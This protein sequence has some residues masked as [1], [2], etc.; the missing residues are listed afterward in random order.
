MKMKQICWLLFGLSLAASSV[1]R[2]EEKSEK[3]EKKSESAVE[4]KAEASKVEENA[5]VDHDKLSIALGH[6]FVRNLTKSQSPL[7]IDKIIDGMKAEIKKK[8]APMTQEE[9]QQ[10][11][12]ALQVE[13]FQALSEK[14]L[15]DANAF[16]EKN[17]KEKDVISLDPKL[18]Y[19][20]VK[21]G[22]G[23]EVLNE[24]SKPLVRVEGKLLDGTVFSANK[25]GDP[26]PLHLKETV[27]GISKGMIGMKK[28]EK[29]TVFIHPEMAFGANSPLPPNSL[30]I[31]DVE[32][33]EM[34]S[35]EPAKDEAA[36]PTVT[37][38]EK[39]AAVQ[40]DTKKDEAVVTAQTEVKK[41]E[42][43]PAVQS[44]VA[45]TD[46]RKAANAQTEKAT[47]EDAS[48]VEKAPTA[49][50]DI[51]K[52]EKVASTPDVKKE[53]KKN[54]EKKSPLSKK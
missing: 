7:K 22:D 44:V 3:V 18:Q 37:T 54:S 42:A 24:D 5:K 19:K 17:G 9:F 2:G 6:F 15:K 36:A 39:A 4:K 47:A 41:G 31:F 14:N 11:M 50:S 33:V 27:P 16:L 46:V 45:S 53:G 26:I 12:V 43:S 28:G 10:A 23:T 35:P 34:K 49:T 8:D 1:V 21:P 40:T 48:K 20:V 29:R 30:I 38:E 32:V 25:E 13:Q 52:E 51:K